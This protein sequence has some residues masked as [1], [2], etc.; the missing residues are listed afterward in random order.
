MRAW[1]SIS[2]LEDEIQTLIQYGIQTILIVNSS[3]D[4]ALS[5][6]GKDCS[7]VAYEQ[8]SAF[9]SFMYDAVKR[10]SMPPYSVK[11]W[12]LGNEPD[13]DPDLVPLGSPYGCWGDKSDIFYGGGYYAEML[14]RVYPQIKAA[15]P[16]A[17]VLVGGL[18]LDCDPVNPPEGK[19]CSPSLFMEGILRSGGGNFFD[20]ISFHAYDYYSGSLQYGNSNWKSNS[21]STGPVVSAKARYLRSLLAAYEHPEKFIMNTEAGLICGFPDGSPECKSAEYEQTKVIYIAEVY[22]AALAEKLRAN[23]WYSLTGWRGTGL[24]NDR[25]EKLPAFQA[26]QT[27][28]RQ[29]DGARYVRMISDIPGLRGYELERG[30]NRIQIIWSIDEQEHAFP[31]NK[32]P[33]AIFNVFG[34]KSETADIEIQVGRSPLY[35]VWDG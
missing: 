32:K 17:Q 11:Y 19:D 13:V 27:S 14:K 9:A 24:I 12:E 16:Q 5:N 33:E 18:L 31:L 15:D 1:D 28:A 20:G 23:I 35:I 34:E 6:P 21:I 3:P 2:A 30:S 7:P 26:F 4:W 22:A 29:L 8:L 25:G 10:Y